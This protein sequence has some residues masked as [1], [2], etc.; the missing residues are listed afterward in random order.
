MAL[1]AVVLCYPH[2]QLN[3]R[4]RHEMKD[5]RASST[6]TAYLVR[7]SANHMFQRDNSGPPGKLTLFQ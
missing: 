3:T 5:I 1:S 2:I 7:I 4:D 6:K